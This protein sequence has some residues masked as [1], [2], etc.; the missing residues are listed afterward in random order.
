MQVDVDTH[1]R[2]GE[3]L[4]QLAHNAPAYSTDVFGS[5]QRVANERVKEIIAANEAGRTNIADDRDVE[6]NASARI[7]NSGSAK[8]VAA[9]GHL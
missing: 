9:R 4:P 2:G 6:R 7:A 8:T 3:R 5:E 1:E